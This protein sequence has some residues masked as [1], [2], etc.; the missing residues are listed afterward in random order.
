[1]AILTLR[2]GFGGVALLTLGLS[3]CQMADMHKP[4]AMDNLP[5]K[6]Q[7]VAGPTR[8][9]QQ[10]AAVQQMQVVSHGDFVRDTSVKAPYALKAIVH[11]TGAQ[12]SENLVCHYDTQ[13]AK[14]RLSL[15]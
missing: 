15:S 10:A 12:G 13:Q 14:A 1:M 8:A 9:C 11:V 2:R 3:A 4:G 7:A 5:P 6:A